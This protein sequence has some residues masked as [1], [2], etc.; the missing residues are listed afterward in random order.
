MKTDELKEL[1]QVLLGIADGKEWQSHDDSGKWTPAAT[2]D[3]PIRIAAAGYNIRLKLWQLPKPPEGMEWH[4][5]DWTEEMLPDGYRPLLSNEYAETGDEW[6][7]ESCN[8]W[9]NQRNESARPASGWRSIFHRTKRPLPQPQQPD[10]YAELKAAHAAGKVI[11]FWC[12]SINQW[13]PIGPIPI[14][15]ALTKYRIKPEQQKVPLGPDD[16]TPGSVVH[17]S[18]EVGWRAVSEISNVAVKIGAEWLPFNW[19]FRYD[20]E[21]KRPTDTSWQPCYKLIDTP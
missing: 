8:E 17:K 11:Q 9:D 18:D 16:I 4:R 20:Y 10:P 5:N 7:H 3:S 6:R 2:F 13:V 14:W 12:E 21:I 15:D 19:L 1:A